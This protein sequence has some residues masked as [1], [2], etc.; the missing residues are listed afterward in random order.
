MASDEGCGPT[1]RVPLKHNA[2]W[3]QLVITQAARLRA[4]MSDECRASIDADGS[5]QHIETRQHIE[6]LLGRAESAADGP[7]RPL[8]WW[9]GSLQDLAWLSL[10]EAEAELTPQLK[11]EALRAFAERFVA[12]ATGLLPADGPTVTRVKGLLKQAQPTADAPA[13]PASK[14][15]IMGPNGMP[16][17]SVLP[18]SVLRDAGSQPTSAVLVGPPVLADDGSQP[19]VP[20]AGSATATL[21]P[22]DRFAVQE[23]V[24]AVFAASDENF[25]QSRGFRNRLIRLIVLSLAA[26][27][28]VMAV[29]ATV[30]HGSDLVKS[31]PDISPL[32]AVLL[33]SL[34]GA[35][36]ALISGVPALAKATGT[37]NPFSLPLY[38][39]LLKVVLGPVF[40]IVGILLLWARWVGDLTFPLGNVAMLAVWA[41]LFGSAQQLVTQVID[42]R[43]ETLVKE[44]GTKTSGTGSSQGTDSA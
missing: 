27:G 32:S 11:D 17:V 29:A 41:V 39:M 21:Q 42:S 24:R 13:A 40:A 43:V 3:R 6:T 26:V 22:L 37:W 19:G 36:G 2:T 18:I 8:Q 25:A 44:P 33:I 10:H 15:N 28:L 34:F 35:V 23:L 14:I 16:A 7:A 38:Q 5:K 30:L 20:P 9:N 12:K 1:V 4:C 31:P